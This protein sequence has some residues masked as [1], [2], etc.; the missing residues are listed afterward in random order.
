MEPLPHVYDYVKKINDFFHK[1]N[2]NLTD[3]EELTIR[4]R[5]T[6]SS[7]PPAYEP[8]TDYARIDGEWVALNNLPW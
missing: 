3:V 8:K 1:I 4:R 6:I 7:D 5:S 2:M